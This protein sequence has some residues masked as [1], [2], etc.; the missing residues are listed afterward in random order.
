MLILAQKSFK[1]K[2]HKP[3]KPKQTPFC[4][5]LLGLRHFI[6]Q[7]PLIIN[8]II[9]SCTL[10]ILLDFFPLFWVGKAAASLLNTSESQACLHTRITWGT[11]KA[12]DCLG[13]ASQVVIVV[14]NPATKAGDRRDACSIPGLGRSPGEGHGNP[15]QYSGL[16]SP[17]D[18]GAWRAT[19]HSVTKSW[20]QL[21]RLST[22]GPHPTAIKS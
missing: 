20:T 13:P 17:V 11:F 14:K 3:T 10:F 19:I 1:V 22:P 18:R 5:S 4:A 9:L 2:T 7:Y 12:S 8:N 15:F 16:E 21:K 6:P